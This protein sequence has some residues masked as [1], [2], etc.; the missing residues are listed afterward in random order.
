[1]FDLKRYEDLQAEAQSL[2]DDAAAL[3]ATIAPKLAAIYSKREALLQESDEEAASFFKSTGLWGFMDPATVGVLYNMGWSN[4]R[5]ASGWSQTLERELDN[6][7]SYVRPSMGGWRPSQDEQAVF[8]WTVALPQTKNLD[9]AKL[10]RTIVFLQGVC[11]AHE[12]F[13]GDFVVNIFEHTLSEYRSYYLV[14]DREEGAWT[15][16]RFTYS[17]MN[18]GDGVT[19][20]VALRQI[21]RDHWYK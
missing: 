18:E 6:Y 7:D 21:S 20:E 8:G 11:K 16:S 2:L 1:M 12:I 19:L 9:E 15:V 5:G 17:V 4:G 14:F 3:K 13:E 10:Q